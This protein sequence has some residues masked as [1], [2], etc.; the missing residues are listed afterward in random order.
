MTWAKEFGRCPNVLKLVLL[1]TGKEKCNLKVE[2]YILFNGLSEDLSPGGSIS[3]SFGGLLQKDKGA[4][5]ICK[6]FA[7]NTRLL[8]H[9]RLLL[10]KENQLNLTLF[11][12]WDYSRI[13]APWNYSFDMY[14]GSQ[15]PASCSVPARVPSGCTVGG[16]R[17]DWESLAV[18][19]SP[20]WIP[21]GLT[22]GLAVGD[23]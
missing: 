8:A 9:Q 14:L 10:I 22:V 20:F 16:S 3:D 12:T 7:R 21:S 18:L 6:S 23:G 13:W 1:S 2:N 15:G 5:R 11:Y 19:L 17:S 4:T